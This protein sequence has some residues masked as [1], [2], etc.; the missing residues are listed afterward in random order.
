METNNVNPYETPQASLSDH[1]TP[2]LL[3]APKAVPVGR[4]W[5]WIADAGGFFMQSP[6]MWVVIGI[7]FFVVLIASSFVPFATNLLTPVL[8]A[9]FGFGC[10]ALEQQKTLEVGHLFEGFNT[11]FGQLVIVGLLGL[12]FTFLVMIPF[13]ILMFV[14]PLMMVG[15]DSSGSDASMLVGVVVSIAALLILGLMIPVIMALWFSP[16]LVAFHDV[17]PFEAM[18]MS[19]KG[20]LKNIMPFLWYGIILFALCIV[21]VVP[22]FLGLLV[23]TPIMYISAYTAY[24]DIFLAESAA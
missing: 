24:K 13:M 11:K 23:L 5:G 22:L 12:L 15:I 1:K 21:A 9:G 14:V 2:E 17:Q 4:G 6:L 16:F 20:C 3:V 18:K 7:I 19:F 10:V 8:M